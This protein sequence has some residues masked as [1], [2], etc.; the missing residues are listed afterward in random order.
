MK[1]TIIT[2]VAA[3]ALTLS[4]NAQ[5]V[6]KV[7]QTNGQVTEF[8]ADEVLSVSFDKGQL[9]QRTM[10]T[11]YLR[12]A[13]EKFARKDINFSALTLGNSVIAQCA[14]LLTAETIEKMKEDATKKV[15]ERLKQVDA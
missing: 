14:S 9:S 7:T 11:T 5:Y 4:A 3:L 1:K 13:L 6:M 2:F 15:Q 8:S 10:L 12:T